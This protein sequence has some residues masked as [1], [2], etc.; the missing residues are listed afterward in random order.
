[1]EERLMQAQLADFDEDTGAITVRN[2][3]EPSEATEESTY[4]RCSQGLDHCHGIVDPSRD[5]WQCSECLDIS[6][7]DVVTEIEGWS[8]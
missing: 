5:V 7:A 8:K 2:P 3:P 6:T 1:M 4:Y